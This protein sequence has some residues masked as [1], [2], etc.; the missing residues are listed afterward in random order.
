MANN[1]RGL[2]IEIGATTT[3]LEKALG[4]VNKISREISKELGQINRSLRFNPGHTELLSQKQKVLKEQ[5]TATRDKL[6]QL[7]DA[8]KQVQ[9]QFK[10]GDISEEQYRAFRR[11]VIETESK[12]K[13]YKKQIIETAKEKDKF[14]QTLQNVGEKLKGFGEKIGDVGKGLTTKITLPLAGVATVA[15]KIGIEFEKSMSEVQAVTGATADEME[16]LEQSARDA[17]ATTDKS[18]KDA[19]DALQYMGLAGWSVADSQKALMPMLKLSSAANMELGRTSDLITDSMSV[20]GLEINDLDGYLDILAQTSRNSNTDVDQLGEAFLAVGGR[21]NMLGVDAKEGAVALGVLADNGK[22]GSEAGKGLNAIITNLTAPTGRA[23]EALEELG[24]SAFDSSGNFIGLEETLK[25][26]ED[27]TKTMTQEQQNMYYSMIA[28][29]EHSD[30]FTALMSG[31]G[32]GFDSLRED[33]NGADGALEEMYGTATD[34]TMG[35]I[36]NLK[37]AVEELALKLFDNLKP[38]IDDIIVVVQGFTDKLNTLTPAQQETVVKIGLI[39]A[40]IGP[41]LLIIGKLITVVG[42]IIGVF[43]KLV[44]IA[45]AVGAAIG[46]LTAPIGLAIAEIAAIIAIGVALYKNWD[47]VKEAAG[48]LGSWVSDKWSNMKESTKENFNTMKNAVSTSMNNI[49]EH[50]QNRLNQMKQTF[51]ENGGGMKGAM[52]AVMGDIKQ[53]WQDGFNVM[54][55]LTGGRLG[56]IVDSFKSKMGQARDVVKN[57]LEKI[58]GF[59]KF[60]WSLPKLKLPRISISGK[61]SLAPPSV[62]KFGIKWNREG[63]IFKR[64]VVLPTMAGLQGFAEQS[65]GGEAITPLNKLPS[66][67]ADA[68]DQSQVGNQ[69]IIE[70]MNVRDETDIEKI[71]QRLHQLQMQKA[72]GRKGYAF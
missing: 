40:A 43:G 33:I 62:P 31:L 46:L 26:V 32:G 3:G 9:E 20:L 52:H 56:N 59:F 63:G 64:P 15:T 70:T 60:E 35:A 67:M 13:H 16:Q 49:K 25:L 2:T 53:N 69:I 10:R 5:I 50:T 14:G 24:V 22:K 8:E 44:T 30:K 57:M 38:A 17:G 7:K 42:T 58:K 34:N 66:L 45:K 19:A 28:G 12:L 71:S 72:R 37:S 51:D 29:K 54:N 65:T 36:N 68:M 23:K 4:S 18:A 48:K 11:E 27:K 21:L 61:F 41:A 1:I 39:V 47:K 55:N 6:Q